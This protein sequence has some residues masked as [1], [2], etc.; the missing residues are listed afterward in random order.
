[1]WLQLCQD[2]D[3]E[4]WQ[5]PG[6]GKCLLGRRYTLQRQNKDTLCFN[7]IGYTRSITNVTDCPCGHVSSLSPSH[8]TYT[9][10]NAYRAVQPFAYQG[11]L[12]CRLPPMAYT[13]LCLFTNN[14]VN[15]GEALQRH[16]LNSYLVRGIM[17]LHLGSCSTVHTAFLPNLFLHCWYLL[18]QAVPAQTDVKHEP[19]ASSLRVLPSACGAFLCS[20]LLRQAHTYR[21]SATKGVSHSNSVPT[22]TTT[23]QLCLPLF[24]IIHC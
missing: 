14:C 19:A 17:P 18:R 5:P 9:L 20:L 10:A 8:S 16:W 15:L 12:N 2:R 6:D 11:S 22:V 21:M 4:T 23:C 1:M 7:G 3:Y 24:F 13:A